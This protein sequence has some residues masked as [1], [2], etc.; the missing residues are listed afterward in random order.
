MIYPD[1]FF[2]IVYS[3]S[4]FTHLPEEMQLSW[5]EELRRVAEKGGYLLLTTHGMELLS[6]SVPLDN[7]MAPRFYYAVGTGTDGLPDFYQT[8][9]HSEDYILNKWSK[10]FKIVRVIRK[11]IANHQD[12]VICLRE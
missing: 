5:L 12:L 1:A 8:S 2:D 6:T 3:V 11:G 10:F 4:V 7:T 9:F